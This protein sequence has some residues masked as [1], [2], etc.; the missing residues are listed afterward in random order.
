MG[1]TVRSRVL[2]AIL[3]WAV[4]LVIFFPILWMG[5]TSL[6]TEVQ[7]IET[8]PLIFFEPTLEN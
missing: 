2:M 1:T 5:I 3:G 4:A 7:A 6:K 8:P